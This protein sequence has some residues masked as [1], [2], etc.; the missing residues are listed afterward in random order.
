[1]NQK[2]SRRTLL[3]SAAVS[4]PILVSASTLGLADE[5]A[6]SER[7][8]VGIIGQGGRGR[9]FLN[10]Y[11]KTARNIE[12]GGVCDVFEP[13]LDDAAKKFPDLPRYTDF[14]KMIEEQKLDGVH[15]ETTTHQR[16]W[17]G[18]QAMLMGVHIYM[19]KPMALTIKEGR[20]LVNAARKL[21]KVV[22]VGTQQRSLPL[23]K[24][25]CEQ[26][27]NGVIGKVKTVLVPNFVGPYPVPDEPKYYMDPK[28][29]PDWWN[30]W[31]NQAKLRACIPEI[32]FGWTRWADYDAGGLCFGVSGWGTHS[33]DQMQMAIGTSLTGPT[34]IR[35]E[36]PCEIRDSGKYPNRAYGEEE[37]GVQYYGMARVTGPRARMT[38]WYE[39][40]VEV[41]FELDG[42][43]GPGLGCIVI[44][45]NG[46]I[47]INRHKVSSNPKE[48]AASLPE[49]CKN[50][51]DETVYHAENW[52]DCI[53]NGGTPNADVEI[54]QRSTTICELVNIVRATA[55]VGKDVHW[56]PVKEEFTDLPEANKLLSRPRR[57]GW[58]LPE[59]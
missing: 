11:L 46:K 57:E 13:R 1:M 10:S 24:W 55:P 58:E 53:K 59:V 5:A 25:A 31:T 32:Q 29:C 23:C 6:P 54:G 30:T 42:D 7:V 21:K 51:R 34:R 22:Q 43:R 14:R 26:V 4:V 16:V 45:E 49:E 36:E 12:I 9:G 15:V 27:A 39:N 2:L 18:I 33:F 17:V 50:K 48:I 41:R 19:E 38:M 40:G 3:K 44:G 28:D 56:D 35:L 52:A 47:E 20:A 8:R 37:T